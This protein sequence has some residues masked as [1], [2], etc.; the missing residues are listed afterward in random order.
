MISFFEN[1][2]KMTTEW[3][4]K[5]PEIC[6]SKIFVSPDQTQT[7]PTIKFETSVCE[8]PVFFY[9]EH[10]SVYTQEEVENCQGRRLCFHC[11]DKI[12][13][14]IE[15]FPIKYTKQEDVY[16]SP[17]PHC[18]LE[19]AFATVCSRTNNSDL[20][21]NFRSMYG[22]DIL[23]APPRELLFIQGGITMKKFH[24]MIDQKIVIELHPTNFVHAFIAPLYTSGSIFANNILPSK[25]QEVINS[26]LI[27]PPATLESHCLMYPQNTIKMPIENP[28][29]S[30]AD[31]FT[32]DPLSNRDF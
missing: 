7:A 29:S 23:S 9:M 4:I 15:F 11:G 26:V 22:C 5:N 1:S 28:L 17:I 32:L 3:E 18:R 14:R 16:V 20:I 19:C 12:M 10:H 2:G 31:T 25:V 24:E 13:K 27:E 21:A 30:I 8:N 6:R